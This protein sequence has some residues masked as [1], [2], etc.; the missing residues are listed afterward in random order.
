MAETMTWESLRR[1]AGFRAEKG[2]AIS[3]YV[4]LDPSN[5]PTAADAATRL[6]S[7]V[8]EGLKNDGLSR[9]DRTHD[10]REQ[11]RADFNRIVQY[12][13]YEFIRD[14]AHGLAIFCSGLDNVWMPMPLTESVADAVKIGRE[15]YLTPL[16]PLVGRGD[17][18]LV[19]A[20]GREQGRIYELRAGRL[21]E[22]VNLFDEQPRRHDQGGWSQARFQ[23]HVDELA[24]GHLREVADE[25]D[26][27]VRRLQ[28]PR[29][30]VVCPEETRAEFG[31][32]LSNDVRNAVAGWAHAEAHASPAE[33]LETARPALD[34]WQQDRERRTLERWREERGRNGRAAG[35]WEQTLEA[36]SDGRVELLLFHE[37]ADHPA[38]QCPACGRV[39]VVGGRCPLDG[40]EM[41]ERTEGLDLAVHQTLA[42]GGSIWA[43][44]SRRDLEP[45]EGIGAILR[46]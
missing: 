37:G 45:I 14:G 27:L 38:W 34:R 31:E 16:V 7:L 8:D 3:L 26:R 19:A 36:A 4:D 23:R 41:E 18:V 40:T 10:Q 43:V 46:Y 28:T 33:L 17:G 9:S 25:L 20:V 42:H 29:L 39:N 21:E 5:T 22:V 11:L 35:G 6:N 2:C 44:G 15:L 30:V 32:L 24:L 1:L 12:F 13:E